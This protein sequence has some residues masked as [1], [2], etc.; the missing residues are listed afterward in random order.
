MYF[1]SLLYLFIYMQNKI[2]K[3]LGFIFLLMLTVFFSCRTNSSTSRQ[4]QVENQ[5]EEKDRQVEKQYNDAKEKHLKNQTRETRKRM[6]SNKV[7]AVQ[8][9]YAKKK[10]FF[11]KRW[12]GKKAPN[13]CP[14][15]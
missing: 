3:L 15:S 4:K 8:S 5:R 11:L 13:T 6:K 1:C 9:G 7:N 2:G 14:K 10:P 12:F